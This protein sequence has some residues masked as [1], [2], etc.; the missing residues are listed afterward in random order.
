MN[1]KNKKLLV[2]LNVMFIGNMQAKQ[3]NDMES[4]ENVKYELR[5]KAISNNNPSN[6]VFTSFDS[7]DQLSSTLRKNTMKE[8]TYKLKRKEKEIEL[9]EEQMKSFQSQLNNLISKNEFKEAYIVFKN[10]KLF[11]NS[12]DNSD[13]NKFFKIINTFTTDNIDFK[14]LPSINNKN[15]INKV[16]SYYF[17]CI[18]KYRIKDLNSLNKLRVSLL[19]LRPSLISKDQKYRIF[20]DL[21]L[22]E[23]EYTNAYNYSF[24]VE[25]ENFDDSKIKKTIKEILIYMEETFYK[26]YLQTDKETLKFLNIKGVDNEK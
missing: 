4:L 3:I 20:R 18:Q 22:V 13:L 1:F 25:K 16:V 21:S 15:F 6:Y 8:H 12:F 26:F 2:L 7:I 9:L 5:Q 24:K 11:D 10:L 14:E 23:G 19:K 17:E